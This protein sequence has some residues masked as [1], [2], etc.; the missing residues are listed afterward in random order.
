MANFTKN[1]KLRKPLPEE[2]YNIEEHNDNMDI[3]DEQLKLLSEKS[4]VVI[5]PD[6]PETGDVWIDTDD[7]DGSGEG[8]AGA[9]SSVNGKTGDVILTAR[10]LDAYTVGETYSKIE[11]NDLL[12]GKANSSHG[13]SADQISGLVDLL[14][15]KA[16]SSHGHHASEITGL[17]DFIASL[18]FGRCATGSYLGD[19]SGENKYNSM[20][21][22]EW[23]NSGSTH[24]TIS[25]PFAPSVIVIFDT[26]SKKMNFA[27]SGNY[28]YVPY[29]YSAG[30]SN[31]GTEYAPVF[32]L[33]GNELHVVHKCFYGSSASNYVNG[34]NKSGETYQYLIV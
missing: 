25:L 5:S 19:G 22:V 16:N 13:H 18:G 17:T 10:D 8:F 27:I 21:G 14:N 29:E 11:V 2:F 30:A 3:I 33:T 4:G 34:S 23:G 28:G 24:R 26:A 32:H 9:V 20:N 1:Y 6:E 7:D 12:N 31:Q 15:G